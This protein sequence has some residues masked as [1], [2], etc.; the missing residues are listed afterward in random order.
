[1]KT[2][3]GQFDL[4]QNMLESETDSQ[5]S[6]FEMSKH[7]NKKKKLIMFKTVKI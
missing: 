5:S 4:S 2:S 1:M 6:Q 7:Q 3:Q